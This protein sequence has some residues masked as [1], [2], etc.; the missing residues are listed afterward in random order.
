VRK[1][2]E[3]KF[4]PALVVSLVIVLLLPVGA[5][6]RTLSVHKTLPQDALVYKAVY[7]TLP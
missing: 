6:M 7:K 2:A 1:L 3:A 4:K 5:V